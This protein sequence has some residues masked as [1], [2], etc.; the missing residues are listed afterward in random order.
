[1]LCI[2][3]GVTFVLDYM[4]SHPQRQWSSQSLTYETS[5]L[6]YRIWL[7][8]LKKPSAV[9]LQVYLHICAVIPEN[10]KHNYTGLAPWEP[11]AQLWGWEVMGGNKNSWWRR[12]RQPRRYVNRREYITNFFRLCHLHPTTLMFKKPSPYE[13]LTVGLWSYRIMRKANYSN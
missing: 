5:V 7:S 1:M 9:H 3:F 11:D 12:M 2:S 8:R 6:H 10:E 4:S 13:T